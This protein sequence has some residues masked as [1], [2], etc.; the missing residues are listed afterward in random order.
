[1]KFRHILC[2]SLLAAV[3]TSAHAAA[4]SSQPIAA[5]ARPATTYPLVV[6][7]ISIG[8]GVSSAAIA[9]YNVIVAEFENYWGVNPQ[10]V[11]APWGRE[12]EYDVCFVLTDLPPAAREEL[13]ESL[14]WLDDEPF[15]EVA[16]NASC[17]W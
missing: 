17:G 11:V 10:R 1:M 16:E 2:L 13:V 12:G 4:P 9:Q 6:S 5:P 15:T 14:L 7:F 8:T 3:A